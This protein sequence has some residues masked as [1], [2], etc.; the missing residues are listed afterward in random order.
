MWVVIQ[1]SGDRD[2]DVYVYG[3]FEGQD[4]AD[5]FARFVTTEVDPAKAYRLGSPLVELLAWYEITKAAAA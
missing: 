2:D 4:A 3:P 5:R 1:R